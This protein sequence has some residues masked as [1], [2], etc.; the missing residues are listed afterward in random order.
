MT[1]PDGKMLIQVRAGTWPDAGD[2]ARTFTDKDSD[3]VVREGTG[4]GEL[5][6]LGVSS[7]IPKP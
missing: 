5:G 2:R 3:S 4:M 6:D 1:S 7:F